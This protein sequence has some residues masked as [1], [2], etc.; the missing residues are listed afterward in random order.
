M[1]LMQQS[2]EDLELKPSKQAKRRGKKEADLSGLPVRRIDYYL[3]EEELEAEFGAKGW[4]QLPDAISR[5]Y[6]FVPAQ[7]EVEEHHIGVY[8]SKTDEAHGD[9]GPSKGV[10]AWKSGI[11]IPGSCD[12]QW[13]ICEYSS[14]LSVRAGIQRL[15]PADH[16]AEH[17]KLVNR[18]TY[19]IYQSFMIIFIKNCIPTTSSRQ[20][21]RRYL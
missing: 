13:K 11:T 18:Y 14:S 8:A 6:H 10:T 17:G 21:R 7:V 16:K 5:K 20:T 3:S 15:W 1:I 4:K 12:H 19:N 9:G 2:P